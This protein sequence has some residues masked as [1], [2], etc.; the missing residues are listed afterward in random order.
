MNGWYQD[1][2]FHSC[3]DVEPYPPT[4]LLKQ[5]DNTQLHTLTKLTRIYHTDEDDD[6]TPLQRNQQ[7]SG[8]RRD[9]DVLP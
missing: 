7:A 4:L 3:G 8:P 1:Y 6:E 5:R 2:M 9:V